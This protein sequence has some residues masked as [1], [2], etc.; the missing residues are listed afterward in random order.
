MRNSWVFLVVFLCLIT[1][2][3]TGCFS[4]NPDDINAFIKPHQVDVA[5]VDYVLQ[6]PD[7]I[8]VYSSKIEELDSQ[9]Q[10]I[11]PDGKVSFE[12]IGEIMAAGRTPE[13]L[14][15]IIKVK[16]MEFYTLAT[17]KPIDVRVSYFRSKKYYV[18]GQ[19]YLPGPKPYSG[20]DTVLEAVSSANPNPMAWVQRIQVIRPSVNE[21][22]K[23]KIFEVD[24]DRMS[25]HGDLSKN[26]LLQEGDVVYVPPTVVASIALKMEEFLRPIGRAFSTVNVVSGSPGYR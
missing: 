25:V 21:G 2:G 3:V 18:L 8:I 20:H 15:E 19:V 9:Q 13:Q 11:R 23:A 7:E 12:N 10:Q 14:A 4:S 1:V 26:V 17:D 5:S 22:E 24:F 6:P 16:I